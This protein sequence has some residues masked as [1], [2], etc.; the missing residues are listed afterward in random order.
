MKNLTLKD[1]QFIPLLLLTP[2]FYLVS[3]VLPWQEEENLGPGLH[4]DLYQDAK[5]DVEVQQPVKQLATQ[6]Y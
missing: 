6:S 1:V 3:Q 2:V 4:P 5:S